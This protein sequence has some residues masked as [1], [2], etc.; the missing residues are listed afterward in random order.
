MIS[1]SQLPSERQAN[2][3]PQYLALRDRIAQGIDAG[4]MLP[5]TR[6]PSER[7]LQS[8]SGAA[9]G[10]IREALFQLEAEGIIYRRDRSGW[11]VTPPP[12]TYD[13]TRWA[14][15][16]T[17]VT[18]QGRTPSTETL[19]VEE[20]PAV[21]ALADIFRVAPGTRLF[22]IN[23]RRSIDG[24]AVLV[25][26]I[27][28]EAALAPGLLDHDLNT[29]LTHILASEYNLSVVRNRV[30]MQPCALVKSAADNLG[31][32]AGTPGLQVVRTSF[33]ARGRVVN[34]DHEYWRHDAI[35][36]HV[37]TSVER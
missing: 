25:E 17:Y 14:G 19:S 7:Q 1:K 34:Y 27:M 21:S 11:Y 22:S 4:K 16:M 13:P 29:S 24:R 28:V 31:V 23:R 18:E 9:R 20:V 12:V 5:G 2:A 35:R 30:D 6:L 26:R 8:E 33:D 36:V 3:V 10:T 37:D 32:K 15:F